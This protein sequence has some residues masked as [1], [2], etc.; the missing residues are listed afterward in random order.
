MFE[1][2]RYGV[3]VWRLQE[4][5]SKEVQLMEGKSSQTRSMEVGAEKSHLAIFERFCQSVDSGYVMESSHPYSSLDEIDQCMEVAMDN[6]GVAA[7]DS[8]DGKWGICI[9][10]DPRSDTRAGDGHISFLVEDQQNN[11]ES[12]IHDIKTVS[13]LFRPQGIDFHLKHH[14]HRGKEQDAATANSPRPEGVWP[15]EEVNLPGVNGCPPLFLPTN[16]FIIRSVM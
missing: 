2:C 14:Q 16:R 5:V 1:A 4:L 7:G 3:P 12:I 6:P 13:M 15:D 8:K 11:N 9:V 10:F